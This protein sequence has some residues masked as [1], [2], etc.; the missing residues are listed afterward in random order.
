M[1]KNVFAVAKILGKKALPPE[2]AKPLRE[3]FFCLRL[4]L[5][6]ICEQS[7]RLLRCWEACCLPKC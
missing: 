1:F 6:I 7:L 2:R 4:F 5:N 3:A